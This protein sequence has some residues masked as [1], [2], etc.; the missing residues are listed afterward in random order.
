VNNESR[1]QK[2][3]ARVGQC[4]IIPQRGKK[5]ERIGLHCILNKKQLVVLGQKVFE[6]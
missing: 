3:P 6:W 1:R 4:F 5:G 2:L